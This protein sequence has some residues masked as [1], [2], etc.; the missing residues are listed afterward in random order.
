MIYIISCFSYVWNYF[1]S[2][3]SNSNY[4]K[5]TNEKGIFLCP[6]C[7]KKYKTRYNWRKHRKIKHGINCFLIKN[8]ARLVPTNAFF[9][10]V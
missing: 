4:I 3:F 8:K 5:E 9:L 10:I 2:Y 7:K 1:L 6:T